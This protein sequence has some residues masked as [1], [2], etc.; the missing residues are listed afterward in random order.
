MWLDRLA[1]RQARSDESFVRHF[2][3]RYDGRMPIWVVT[4]LL[5]FGQVSRLYGGANDLATEVANAF[6]VP[7]S[8]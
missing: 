7:R 8:S 5:E 3:E 1:E 6:D 4:E 2:R